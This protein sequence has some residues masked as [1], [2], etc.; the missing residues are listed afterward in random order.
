ME[1]FE[2][3]GRSGFS[4]LCLASIQR[5]VP[6]HMRIDEIHGHAGASHPFYLAPFAA[7]Y[8]HFFQRAHD[9]ADATRRTVDLFGELVTG[10]Q[11]FAGI[12]PEIEQHQ[13]ESMAHLM[14]AVI[15][16][17][18]ADGVPDCG[19]L[20]TAQHGETS[21]PKSFGGVRTRGLLERVCD[22]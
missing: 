22:L 11:Y 12:L 2:L 19:G 3:H 10:E 17:Q 9:G 20:H 5:A 21:R 4:S 13:I 7:D 15:G 18:G 1:E 16:W 8:A 14:R 6:C